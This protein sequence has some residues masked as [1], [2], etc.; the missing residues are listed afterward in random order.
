VP[1]QNGLYPPGLYPPGLYPPSLYGGIIFSELSHSYDTLSNANILLKLKKSYKDKQ[2]VLILGAGVSESC[3]LP[4]WSQLLKEL[5]LKC[6]D[7]YN[8][9]S[10][11]IDGIADYFINVEKQPLILAR[12]IQQFLEKKG[13]HNFEETM[14]NTLYNRPIKESDLIREICQ[15][16]DSEVGQSLDSIITYNY[17]DILET[18][19]RKLNILHKAIYD[20][21]MVPDEGEFPIY[22][23][24]GF[25]PR[26]T[27]S[28]AENEIIL[29][30][31]MY[32]KQYIDFYDW[33]NLTQINKFSQK[34]CLFIGTSLTD[35]NMRRLLDIASTQ[36]GNKE[37]PHFII[38]ERPHIK[39][40][41]N[42]SLE[43]LEDSIL[44]FKAQ[45]AWSLGINTLWVDKRDDIPRELSKIRNDY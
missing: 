39:E 16:F 18:Y 45:D 43:H 27:I 38:A 6:F 33:S 8:S 13:K 28:D 20:T 22:H 23:V 32:H 37:K 7:I 17:D 21:G 10:T 24:H 36:R 12:Y 11:D 40:K 29:S 44:H 5:L 4:N 41:H 25:L 34:T 1:I 14:R 30:E 19:L 15:F 9:S 35:P 31:R 26:E 2:L 42:N 3:G